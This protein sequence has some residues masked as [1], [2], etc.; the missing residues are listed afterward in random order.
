MYSDKFVGKEITIFLLIV[1]FLWEIEDTEGLQD[2]VMNKNT[3]CGGWE[4]GLRNPKHF[5][6]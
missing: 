1:L 6:K 2:T 3:S 5:Y 4:R